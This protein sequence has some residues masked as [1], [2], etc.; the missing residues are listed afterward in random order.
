[1]TAEAAARE[2][3]RTLHRAG[4]ETYFVG[5][6]VRD[7]LLGREPE[8]WDVATAAHPQQ[9]APLFAATRE[10]G[11]HFGV[12]QVRVDAVWIEV[13]TF[14]SEGAYSDGRRPDSV[15]FTDA[16][17]DA[18]RRD[19]T[20]NALFFDPE[21]ARVVDF[22]GGENDLRARL[23]RAVGDPSARFAEDWLRLLR[24]VRFACKLE[25]E[26]EPL[27]WAA[28]RAAAPH[29]VTTSAERVRDE[30][31]AMLTGPA[32]RRA[33]EL[34]A[35]SGLLD[36]LLPEVAA[37]RGVEQSPD[38]HPE[39]DVWQHVLQM[40]DHVREPSPELALG[41]LLHDIGKPVTRRL[42]GERTTFYGHVEAGIDIA[43]R[44][45]DRLRVSNATREV[46]LAEIGQHMR[47]LD[48]PR[49]KQSTRRRFVLQPHFDTILELHRLDSLGSSGDLSRWQLCRDEMERFEP[50]RELARPLL[51]GNDLQ[52]AGL[53]PG[54]AL[55]RA[56][57][58]LVDAQLEGEVGDR[59]AA[60]AWLRKHHAP[61]AP[62]EPPPMAPAKPPA[63]M[64]PPPPTPTSTPTP[65]P[66]STPTP[67]PTP[68]RKPPAP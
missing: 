46:V 47:F 12:L 4:Y 20:V 63:P 54:P 42:Q 9:A 30:L 45:L 49:M 36:V 31:L 32:P 53:A 33:L 3:V 27:T 56:L 25:F 18:E 50:Q 24:C 13:A 6:C 23:V 17:N 67:T 7:R 38:H 26:I 59:D 2:V 40:F 48:T 8:D 43:T 37:L 28:L 29:I 41:I 19:F 64:P 60:W 61:G 62:L 65:T 11:R 51:D 58:A 55:G 52:Y 44:V 66:T 16:R 68:T 57:H 14:R 5:G 15:R 39:G 35:A 21:S 22:V 34:L 1:M 10:V